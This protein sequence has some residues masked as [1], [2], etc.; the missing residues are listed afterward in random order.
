MAYH[1]IYKYTSVARPLAPDSATGKAVLMLLPVGALLGAFTAWMDA[2]PAARILHQAVVYF[3][4]VYGSWAL[5]RELDPDD[6][7]AAFI[8]LVICVLVALG[9][10]S[11]GILIVFTTLGLVRIVNRSS[12]LAARKSDSFILL[13]LVLLVIYVTESPFYGVVAGLAFILDGTLREPLRHQWL[14]GLACI[15]ATIVYIVDH[16]VGIGN[17]AA[18]DTL[19]EWLAI[20]F[21][22]IFALNTLLLKRVRAGGDANGATLDLGRVRGGMAVGLFAA[23]QG[24]NRPDG[25]VIIVG[26][27]AGICIGMALRKGFRA[28]VTS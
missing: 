16:D 2:E 28:P 25:V 1:R 22:L 10:D 8:S 26:V 11:P 9:I 21:L 23:V 13:L 5:A 17:I 12:G 3:L 19:F 18:P 6:R 24:V 27:I 20:L 4:V 14:F 7:V 15:G